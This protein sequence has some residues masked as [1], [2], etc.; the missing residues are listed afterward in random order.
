[1]MYACEVSLLTNRPRKSG[2]CLNNMEIYGNII[3]AQWKMYGT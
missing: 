2:N 3:F 1:M